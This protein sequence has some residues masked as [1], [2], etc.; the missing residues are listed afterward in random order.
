[1]AATFLKPDNLKKQFEASREYYDNLRKPYDEFER[2]KN[3]RPHPNIDPVYP[4]TT[5]GTTAS[6]VRLTPRRAIQQI[7]YGKVE[8]DG[9]PALSCLAD[10]LLTDEIVP[11]STA[12]TDVLGKLWKGVEDIET[13]GST[14]AVVFYKVDGEYFGTDWRIPYKKDIYG[15]A[16]KGTANEW[17]FQFMRAWYQD[18]DIQDIIDKEQS[19]VKSAKERGE[20]YK[21]TWNL[22][23]LQK[24]LDD[25]SK[26]EKET[27]DKTDSEKDR[28]IKVEGY[29]FIHAY[30]NGVGAKFY[31]FL[32][33]GK[34]EAAILREWANPDPR[35]VMPGH[36]MYFE[37]D[38]SNPEGRGIV[39]LVAPLQNYLDSSLQAYQYVR[40]LMYNPPLLKKGSYNRNQ[41]KFYPNHI[42]DLGSNP[43]NTLTP[44]NLQTSAISNFSNDFGLIKSQILNLFGGDDQTISSTVGNPGF[45]KTDAGVNARQE[46]KGVNDNFIRKR[47][48]AWIGDIWCTQVNLYFAITEGDREFTPDEDTLMKLAEY[49]QNDYYDIVDNKIVVHFSNIQDRVFKFETEASTSKATDTNEAKE[50]FQEGLKTAA[51]IGLLQYINPQ[52]ATKRIL[53]QAGVDDPEKLLIDPQQMMQGQIDPATGQPIDPMAEQMPPE[54][55]PE[56]P[57]APQMNPEDE[58]ILNNLVQSGYTPEEAVK[59]L[60]LEKQGYA[61]EEIDQI[62]QGGN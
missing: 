25:K 50:N 49:G 53:I 2:I 13:Y 62:L 11:N 59:G 24:L 1:L 5:D 39:E 9:E 60:M 40:A 30:Q 36:R 10:Y 57:Q 26:S 43:E 37:T 38:L 48:E 44:L 6:Q 28:N 16:G 27:K 61:P 15:E 21:S 19:L 17:N 51:E 33:R 41:I 4:Q 45:S 54:V 14:D 58:A 18:S 29:E 35:G 55:A 22:K 56:Q 23:E 32:L 31:T 34:D 20:K 47:V 42:I 12:Q 3:N 46:I 52:E 7:P 8:V